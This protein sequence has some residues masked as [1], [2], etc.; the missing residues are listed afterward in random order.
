MRPATGT[1]GAAGRDDD[2]VLRADDA[3]GATS[4]A[5]ARVMA[6]G[7]AAG[8]R[9][10]AARGDQLA[11]TRELGQAV[12]PRAG[13][14]AAVVGLPGGGVARAGSRRRGPRR[15]RPSGS[16]GDQRGRLAV[17]QGE[18]DE[19]GVGEQRRVGRVEGPV[20]QRGEVRVQRRS[21]A[22]RRW[23]PRRRR[24]ARARGGRGRAGAAR[25]PHTRWLPRPRPAYSC[26][27]VYRIRQ[28]YASSGSRPADSTA[29][30][31][32]P[33][34]DVPLRGPVVAGWRHGEA[35]ARPA[36]SRELGAG[37]RRG[38]PG[39]RRPGHGGRVG[40]RGPG[41][42]HQPRRRGRGLRRRGA[43]AAPVGG[44]A[45]HAVPRHQDRRA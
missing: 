12:R 22:G 19:V 16:C 9:D 30:Q 8:V 1:G 2:D 41:G 42:R 24:R 40:G 11:L 21:P 14:R 35:P 34:G 45:G 33:A 15:G 6:D 32:E 37:L 3:A 7:V 38:C 28:A 39:R 13:V 10:P 26:P 20:G 5:R 43:A 44:G 4:G 27:H 29:G 18:E 31:P 36:W 25:R 23:R 17:R